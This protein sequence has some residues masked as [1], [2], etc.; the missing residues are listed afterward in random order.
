MFRKPIAL[1]VMLILAFTF[2]LTGCGS[3]QQANDQKAQ[4]DQTLTKVKVAECIRFL[5]YMPVYVGVTKGFFKEEGLD[6]SISTAGG[7]S[8]AFSAVIG[9]SAD[10]AVA[11]PMMSAISKDKGGPGVD[12][13]LVINKIPFVGIAK[14]KT[15]TE[16]TDASQFKG[17]TVVTYPKPMT[18]YTMFM[19]LLKNAGL[20]EGT[21]AKVIQAAFGT[22]LGP[23]EVG[24][25]QVAMT[26]EPTVSNAMITQG[27]HSVY[28]YSKEWGEFA[29]TGLMTTE[30]YIKKNP[31]VVQKLMNGIQ[32]SLNYLRS[33]P[34]D[35]VDVAKEWFPDISKEVLA[36]A[37][38]N[39]VE[40]DVWPRNAAVSEE[41]WKKHL[42]VRMELGDLSKAIPLEEGTDNTFAQKAFEQL[43]KK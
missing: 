4:G 20:K 10:F 17:L 29:F 6:V 16:I 39:M 11:D 37:V 13:G 38:S 18:N 5:G 23:I 30:E 35:A 33:N 1:M 26:L 28:S 8:Q 3:G 21:D 25:A 43:G 14:D 27:Y 12:L 41:A 36:S 7:D 34:E 19:K 24:K 9:G 40:E 31:E 15:V 2:L 32:K 42:D 22:E